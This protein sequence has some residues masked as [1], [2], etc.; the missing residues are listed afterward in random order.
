MPRTIPKNILYPL[1]RSSPLNVNLSRIAIANEAMEAERMTVR[2]GSSN[3]SGTTAASKRRRNAARQMIL[4]IAVIMVM[5]V[6]AAPPVLRG[7]AR[8]VCQAAAL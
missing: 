6:V 1:R 5:A 8:D 4:I 7:S 2:P 3:A